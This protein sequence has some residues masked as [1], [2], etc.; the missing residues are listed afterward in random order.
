MLERILPASVA[1][2]STRDEILE[3]VLYPEEEAIVERAVEK[4]R[5]EFTTSRACA[6]NALAQLDLPPVPIATGPRGEPRWPA[7]I[8]GSITHCD[9][10]RASALARSRD[11]A[12][13]GVDA[14]PNQPLPDGLLED[15]ALPEEREWLSDLGR[16]SS[17]T[18]WD[19]LLFSIKESVY[20]AWYPLA[21]KW[22]GF[23]DAVV[24][25]DW[26]Q[27][28]FSARLLVPGPVFDG[29]ELTGFDG[30]WLAAD[31]LVMAAI[32][33]PAPESER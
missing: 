24:S 18:H 13:L 23:E 26:E 25:I 10:Y 4:R 5:R 27:K 28:S 31:G 3:A 15:I 20:K 30:R 32:A 19:R 8:V 17:E 14:E 6:R 22:L 16:R 12:T 9:G 33:L 2:A 21:E 7:G 1:V 11:L 29:R